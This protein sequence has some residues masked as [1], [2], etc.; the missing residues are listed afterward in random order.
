MFKNRSYKEKNK[1]LLIGA[2]LFIIL[3][4]WMAVGRTVSLYQEIIHLRAQV[5]SVQRAPSSIMRLRHQ[6]RMYEA[7]L[8]QFGNSSQNWEDHLL[9]EVAEVCQQNRVTLIQLPPPQIEEQSAYLVYTR[10]LKIEGKY[11]ALV[12]ALHALEKKKS[13][14][15]INS[16]RF[17]LEVDRNTRTTYL[18]AYVY[19]QHIERAK[20]SF[21]S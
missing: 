9:H 14:G 6:L 10:G 16:V 17:A 8:A 21:V 1:L 15:R 20:E 13:I 7:S 18:F 12:Q 5:D 19:I 11:R 4:Y 2:I 3:A